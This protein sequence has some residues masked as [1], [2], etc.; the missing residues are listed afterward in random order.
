MREVRMTFGEHLEE[1]RRRLI[2]ALLWLGLS[3]GA[4][5]YYGKGLMHLT[6]RPHESAI[7]GAMNKSNLQRIEQSVAGLVEIQE[8]AASWEL[9]FIDDLRERWGREQMKKVSEASQE[10][11]SRILSAFSPEQKKQFFTALEVVSEE[12]LLVFLPISSSKLQPAKERGYVERFQVLEKELRELAGRMESSSFQRL[13]GLGVDFDKVIRTIAEFNQFL[14]ARR[15]AILEGPPPDLRA[16][17]EQLA[18]DQNLK[19]IDEI[20]GDLRKRV[21]EISS[22]KPKAPILIKYLE[23]FMSYFKV[24]LIFGIFFALPLILFEMWKF[25]GAGLYSHE[26][27]YVLMIYPFSILL[28]LGGLFF[29][30]FWMVPIS[31]QFLASWG[32]DF[33]DL[34]FTLENY[35]NLFFTLTVILGLVFQT[36][37]VMIFLS[38]I[39]IVDAKGF[40][41]ARKF[42][43]LGAIV[44]AIIVTPP[45]PLSW[46]LVAS[47][48]YLLYEAGIYICQLLERRQKKEAAA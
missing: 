7:K 32:A 5:L 26:Q 48:I 3:T 45:D 1:L 4:C 15:K 44:F 31:L 17:M 34:N 36:P 6:M 10:R 37:L 12:L 8:G 38:Q 30:Y 43:V 27:K 39:G 19:K 25:I 18:E 21:D 11:I 14:E 40:K 23:G 35:V 16:L 41:A 46:F 9:L 42:T 2:G 24:A 33:A 20:Y 13:L 28:F 29:G 22:N 47:P